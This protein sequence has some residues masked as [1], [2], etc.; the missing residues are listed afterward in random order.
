MKMDVIVN[1]ANQVLVYAR[2]FDLDEFQT[3]P[4]DEIEKICSRNAK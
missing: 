3:V 4:R 2:I 1:T